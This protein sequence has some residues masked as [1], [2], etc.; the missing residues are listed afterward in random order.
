M[1]HFCVPLPLRD[2]PNLSPS[3]LEV[4]ATEMSL[5]LIKSEIQVPQKLPKPKA[6]SR[7]V[8]PSIILQGAFFLK[9]QGCSFLVFFGK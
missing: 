1:H 5:A 3:G 7:I 2:P 6:G 8:F 9:L 4:E